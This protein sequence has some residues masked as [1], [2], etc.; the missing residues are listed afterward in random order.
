MSDPTVRK[1]L[2]DLECDRAEVSMNGLDLSTF[3]IDYCLTL[4]EMRCLL[5]TTQIEAGQRLYYSAVVAEKPIAQSQFGK[6]L[7]QHWTGEPQDNRL[8]IC[9]LEH[10]AQRH[11][12]EAQKI[13]KHMNLHW[14]WKER[15][16]IEEEEIAS[17]VLRINLRKCELQP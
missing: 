4:E 9:W 17:R 3:E 5:A 2:E 7:L 6:M 13:L 10:A 15:G 12:P 1:E 11:E 14:T 8:A 16:V